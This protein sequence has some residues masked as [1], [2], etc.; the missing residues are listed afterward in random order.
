MASIQFKKSK[1]GKKIYYVVVSLKGR[2]KWIKAGSQKDAKILKKHIESIAESERFEKLGF[3]S[4][5]IRIDDFFQ[6][7]LNHVRLHTSPNT[8]KRYKSVLNTFLVFLNMFH[9]TVRYLSQIKIETIESYQQKRLE[10]VEL[11]STADG[12]KN[13]IHVNKKL[14]KPQTVNYEL[15]VLRSA[16]IWAKNRE[17][18]LD[19]P[20]RKVKKL[21]S[22]PVRKVQ[23]LSPEQ[24][25]LL[26]QTAKEMSLED[27]GLKVYYQAFQF[28]LNTGLRSGELCN[29][30]WEDVDLETSLI[31]IQAKPGWT[32]KS[33]ERSFF[34]N[35][36][37]VRLL[38]KIKDREGYIFATISGQQLNSDSLR[39]VLIKIAK[40]A[41]FE[42]LTRVHDLRHTFN[43]IMQMNGVDPATMG[44]I[45]GHK[46]IETTMIYTHQTSEHL[47]K[48]I[49]KIGVN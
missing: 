21:K 39:K 23:I 36:M 8:L 45:L 49:E 29:L 30:T 9:P 28:I 25:K 17:I 13:G 41:G 15:D 22:A 11:K 10:S 42:N 40:V 7:Y 46:D 4:R 31:K 26:L 34:L 32:P 16:F 1:S 35:Q 20:T 33:Y 38:S 47:K 3:T 14:P 18:I 37:C 2:H 12:E 19:I 27:Q 24:C 44:K 6:D 48:S 43:S 5:D